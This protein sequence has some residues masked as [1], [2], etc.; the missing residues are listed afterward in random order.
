MMERFM[1]GLVI[2]MGL[3]ATGVGIATAMH[4]LRV[5]GRV[6]RKFATLYATTPEGWA[7]WFLGGFSSLTVGSHWFWATAAL[8]GWSVAGL[9]LIGLGLQ[10]FWRP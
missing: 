6:H 1:S 3:I 7:S 8:T 10:L 4:R 9:C 2:A 5:A